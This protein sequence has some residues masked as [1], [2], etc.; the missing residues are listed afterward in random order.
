MAHRKAHSKKH[1]TEDDVQKAV[2]YLHEKR[3]KHVSVA[4]KLFNVPCTTLRNRWFGFHKSANHSQEDRQHLTDPEE[5]V[6]CDWITYRSD[7]GQPL[8]KKQVVKKVE[9]A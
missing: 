6:L 2:Q 5:H 3:T 9:L 4:A 8:T 7:T 1:Y